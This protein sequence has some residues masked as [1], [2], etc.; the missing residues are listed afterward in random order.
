MNSSITLQPQATSQKI[1]T[2]LED[3]ADT[4]RLGVLIGKRFIGF[5]HRDI[6][7]GFYPVYSEFGDNLECGDV[8]SMAETAARQLLDYQYELELK[9]RPQFL[10]TKDERKIPISYGK[11]APTTEQSQLSGRPQATLVRGI[12]I[13]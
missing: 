11:P 1:F 13:D 5:I 10:L 8:A 7:G 9:L 4:N 6:E 3:A 2:I 12:S